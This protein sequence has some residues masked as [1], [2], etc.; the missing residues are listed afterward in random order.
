MLHTDVSP[1]VKGLKFWLFTVQK[2][3][4][5]MIKGKM[6]EIG[7]GWM[8]FRRWGFL[9]MDCLKYFKIAISKD[10][11][12]EVELSNKFLRLSINQKSPP[13]NKIKISGW[14]LGS[15]DINLSKWHVDC[16]LFLG[17]CFFP[18]SIW[19]VLVLPWFL[20]LEFVIHCKRSIPILSQGM[21][22]EEFPVISAL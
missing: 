17:D 20:P 9:M 4:G 22:F 12:T 1:D 18:S 2:S 11:I 6:H 16:S 8:P 3:S 10:F 19:D 15:E 13:P 7:N 21:E 14:V 5:G